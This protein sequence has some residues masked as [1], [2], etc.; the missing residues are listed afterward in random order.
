MSNLDD[1][2]CYLHQHRLSLA[3]A[4]DVGVTI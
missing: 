1:R 3:T 4:A 2:Q